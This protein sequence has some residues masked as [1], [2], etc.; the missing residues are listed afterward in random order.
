MIGKFG[1]TEPRF[2]Q[3]RQAAAPSCLPSWGAFLSR[4]STAS[5]CRSSDFEPVVGVE[6]LGLQALGRV[7][8]DGRD[9]LHSP[10]GPP[11]KT[12]F[13]PGTAER[14]V[15]LGRQLDGAADGLVLLGAIDLADRQHGLGDLPRPLEVG[16]L[17]FE[18]EARPGSAGPAGSRPRDRCRPRPS[19]AGA[20]TRRPRTGQSAAKRTFAACRRVRGA[21][22]GGSFSAARSRVTKSSTTLPPSSARRRIRPRPFEPL[23]VQAVRGE[24]RQGENIR[25][26][27]DIALHHELL[28]RGRARRVHSIGHAHVHL[29]LHL[30]HLHAAFASACCPAYPAC[31]SGSAINCS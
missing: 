9:D 2:R 30:L 14:L 22:L 25:I 3:K 5:F 11:R 21:S 29:H 31:C 26:R 20:G 8:T 18:I 6:G 16:G 19:R 1:L 13:E 15:N 17:L 27:E 12:L 4:A 23:V 7:G 28:R 10:L 24:A